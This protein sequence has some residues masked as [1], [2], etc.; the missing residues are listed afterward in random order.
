MDVNTWRMD[1]YLG[2]DERPDMGDETQQDSEI[3]FYEI[4]ES[5]ELPF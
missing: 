5:N 3:T 1:L 2:M 4:T